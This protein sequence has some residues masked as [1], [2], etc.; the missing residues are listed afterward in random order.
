MPYATL[1]ALRAAIPASGSTDHEDHTRG[2]VD[3]LIAGVRKAT[4]TLSSADLLALDSTPVELVAAP[5]AGKYLAVHLV[6][7]YYTYGTT[8]YDYADGVALCY[9]DISNTII[10][11][12]IETLTVATSDTVINK[13]PAD[14]TGSANSVVNRPI[15]MSGTAAS[16]GDGTLT[17]TVWYSIE[18]VP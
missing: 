4:V 14:T 15:A 16:T 10:V 5:G 18:D 17:L 7:G 9:T 2:I 8:V 12:L 6:T 11:D 1:E 13:P 3:A